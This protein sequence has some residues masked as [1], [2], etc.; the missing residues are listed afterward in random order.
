MT[1]IANKPAEYI[2]LVHKRTYLSIDATQAFI[3]AETSLVIGFSS[4][5]C[6][7]SLPILSAIS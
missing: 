4:M 3:A 6:F 1:I 2:N 7:S 5:S